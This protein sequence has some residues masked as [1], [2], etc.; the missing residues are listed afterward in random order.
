MVHWLRGQG[1]Q[2]SAVRHRCHGRRRWRG[3]ACSPAI[4]ERGTGGGG[5]QVI[6]G[7]RIAVAR[8][9]DKEV[10]Q[11]LALPYRIELVP[12]EGGW[13]VTIP[14]WPGCLSQ[15]ATPQEA[16]EMIR[17]AQRLWLHIAIEDGKP[18]PEPTP[19]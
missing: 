19:P 6:A 14:D 1:R 12:D 10:E 5:E 15:G 9:L 4:G 13:F 17:D 16:L 18:I 2:P 7:T 3:Y 8:N 11:H